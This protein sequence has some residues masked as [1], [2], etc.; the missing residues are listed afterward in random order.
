M[1]DSESLPETTDR[2]AA[3][4]PP[5]PATIT[6]TRNQSPHPGDGRSS[7]PGSATEPAR[8]DGWRPSPASD[9][10]PV[11][12]SSETDGPTRFQVV[13]KASAKIPGMP[14]IPG[15]EI[16]AEIGR[17][18][19]GVVY[20]AR[21]LDLNRPVALKM[22]IG[23]YE[24]PEQLLRFRIEAET[25]A[26]V[27]HP[28]VVQV[29]DSGTCNG[30]PYLVLEWVDGGNLSK[31]VKDKP[32]SARGAARTVSLLAR[33]LHATHCAGIV[34][35][36]LK[37]GNILVAPNDAATTQT[38]T[39]G[40]TANT[41]PDTLGV[42]LTIDG[43][44]V[45]LVPKVTDFGL[46]KELTSDVNLTET[47]R[48][49]GTPEYMAPEQA[50]G[51]TK[52]IG[53]ATDVYALGIILY[54]LLTGRTPFRDVNA[55]AIMRRVVEEEPKPPRAYERKVP[56]DLQTICLKCI[57]K[58]PARRYATA[59]ALAG[60]LDCFLENRPITARP[61][62]VV[63]RTWK[64]AA[65]RPAVAA[66]SAALVLA[67]VGGFAGVTWQWRKAEA[68][69]QVAVGQRDRAVAAEREV[70]TEKAVSDAVNHFVLEDLL[71]TATPEKQLGRKITVEEVL[72]NASARIDG[73]FAD[74]PEVAAAI[75]VVLGNGY[76]K[77]GEFDPAGRHLAAGVEL[78]RT[79]LGE[80]HR[81]TLSAQS[82][83]GLLLAD[84]RNWSEAIPLLRKVVAH[85]QE[86]FGPEDALTVDSTDRLALVLQEHGDM[87]EAQDLYTRA[88]STARRVF[89]P[90]DPRT[91]TVLNDYGMLLQARKKLSEA[92]ATYREAADGRAKSLAPSHPATLESLNNLAAVLSLEGRWKE[93]RPVYEKVL[94][95]KRRILPPDHIDLLATKNNFANV[96][97]DHGEYEAAL[98]YY[99]EAYE[100][101]RRALGAENPATL[102]LQNSLG[103][104]HFFVGQRTP[105]SDL[106]DR[107]IT[108]LEA[109]LAVRRRILPLDHPDTLQ[110]AHDLGFALIVKNK[111]PEAESLLKTALAGRR[112][113][114][115]PGHSD[116]LETEINYV[117]CLKRL[118]K[119]GEAATEC[120]T[121][122]AAAQQDGQ[123]ES[124]PGIHLLRQ[125]A[126]LIA[127]DKPDEAVALAERA[128]TLAQKTFGEAADETV[129]YRERCAIL[130]M[131]L[132]R[133]AGA[134]P[135][136]RAA[137]TARRG[138]E[139]NSPGAAAALVGAAANLGRCL[140]KQKRFADAE[141]FVLEAFTRASKLP[142]APPAVVRN[143]GELV[144]QLYDAWGKPEKAAE[145]REK[146]K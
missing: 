29:Y 28:N 18:G 58:D 13:T 130:L 142:T 10:T 97:R 106:M 99:D 111:L 114:L 104:F 89:G 43:Q 113:A 63:E 36:D 80:T 14:E 25:A 94:A 98:E 136:F 128:V 116:T 139:D 121:A 91:L 108:I 69:E 67:F 90:A 57:Q 144:L 31:Y 40:S 35:R 145:W 115:G 30:R 127:K 125:L 95:E 46:A 71:S 92:E 32:Q 87:A 88:L 141:P 8:R 137:Y 82:D 100:G 122:L 101:F 38:R 34:H 70:R 16:V 59:E 54:Q 68:A 126:E 103:V 140:A 11:A 66:L 102:K 22:I 55:V 7:G 112:K 75:R 3:D 61:I 79:N 73:R 56:G 118:K 93:A 119:L 124:R 1:A 53:P 107:G 21:Q 138:T 110:S 146:L 135:H 49:L 117:E 45:G 120:R 129:A 133:T 131:G 48:V 74:Q 26:R 5:T 20:K 78:L 37:P 42:T 51:R 143:S 6:V 27:R 123:A 109:V 15:Y 76:R 52:E 23:E 83:R 85:A 65:R 9:A 4:H 17:G 24:R 19:M 81:D 134:E 105:R 50:A 62:G 33:A 47:G 86:S 2:L 41:R 96:L 12:S 72:Q 77:L 39:G 84:Q 60:D 64:W 44:S 132:G